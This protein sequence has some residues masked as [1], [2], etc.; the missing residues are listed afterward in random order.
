MRNLFAPLFSVASLKR[1][2]EGEK[3]APPSHFTDRG[4]PAG[5]FLYIL[6]MLLIY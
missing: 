5:A 2:T 1:R 4:Q 6:A 3:A